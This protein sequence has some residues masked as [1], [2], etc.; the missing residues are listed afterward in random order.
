MRVLFVNDVDL[1]TG[2]GAEV[3]LATLAD[4]MARTGDVVEVLAGVVEHVGWR[5]LL[6]LHDPFAARLVR[7]AASDFGADIVHLHNVLRELSPSVIGASAGRPTVMTLHD[8]R[9]FADLDHGVDGPVAWAQ[10]RLQQPWAIRLAR[11]HV[12]AFVAVS[13]DLAGAARSAGLNPVTSVAQ[14]T[15]APAEDPGPAGDGH[16]VLFAGRLSQNKGIHEVLAMADLLASGPHADTVIEIAGDGPLADDVAA[17]PHV[18]ALGRLDRSAMSAAMTRARV[19]VIPSRAEL[20][21]EGGS[22]VAIEAARHGRPAVIGP[23]PAVCEVALPLGHAVATDGSPAALAKEVAALLADP[24]HATALGQAGRRS[25]TR[26][27]PDVVA[28]EVRR[29]HEAAVQSR[30]HRASGGRS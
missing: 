16:T 15:E 29:I 7:A 2:G 13:E 24:G 26:H 4:A 1:S 11:R 25:A 18:V 28:A 23:D 14:P 20:Y 19:I 22:L 10:R 12:D 6:D 17:C 9:L 8:R 21:R 5:R 3:Y 27:D 30:A